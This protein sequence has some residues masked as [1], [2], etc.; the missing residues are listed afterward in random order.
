MGKLGPIG[1]QIGRHD[2]H[3]LYQCL[4][5]NN[6]STNG[7]DCNVPILSVLLGND[8]T[9]EPSFTMVSYSEF[10]CSMVMPWPPFFPKATIFHNQ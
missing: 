2:A 3:A 4:C 10:G 9:P 7:T 8:I 6:V 1:K 5:I